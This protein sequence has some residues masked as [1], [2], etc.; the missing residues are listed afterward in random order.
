[1][2]AGGS[3][4]GRRAYSR[5]YQRLHPNDPW[6]SP[7]AIRFID[8]ALVADGLGLEWGSGRSTTWLARRVAR[9]I[10][11]EHD[12][13]WFHFVERR[14][15]GLPN[16]DLRFVPLDHPT[17]QTGERRY[18]PTPGY[19]RVA[20]ELADESVDFVLVDGPYRQPCVAAALPK[21][22]PGGLL[23]ID[24]TDWLPIAEWGVPAAWPMRHQSRNLITQT[25]VWEK[26]GGHGR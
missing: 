14:V 19:V 20:E 5:L 7:K 26:P 24:N 13:E 17:A 4:L 3:L 22:R 10:S 11:V 8:R 15:E 21:L 23:A 6:L 18:D 2:K 9:L 12:P 1:M 25:T 16:V